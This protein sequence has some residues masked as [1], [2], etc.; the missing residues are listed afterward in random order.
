MAKKNIATFLAP[1]KGLVIT[2]SHCYAYSGNVPVD[3]NFGE[4]L[5]FHSGKEYLK[6]KITYYYADTDQG[7]NAI[8]VLALNGND[9]HQME[10]ANALADHTPPVL[11]LIIP[12]LTEVIITG[13]NASDTDIRQLGAVLTG[14]VYDA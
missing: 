13:K 8:F 7:D 12:P 5:N 14:R 9:I 11:Y 6:V 4:L 2:G 3:N 1:S 10:M